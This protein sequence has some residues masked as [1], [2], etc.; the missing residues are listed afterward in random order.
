MVY[1][2][3]TLLHTDSDVSDSLLLGPH[4]GKKLETVLT[5][6]PS[7]PMLKGVALESLS[8]ALCYLA[9]TSQEYTPLISLVQ[10]TCE[11]LTRLRA[12]SPRGWSHTL[13]QWGV[14]NLARLSCL[15]GIESMPKEGVVNFMLSQSC[16]CLCVGGHGHC[17]SFL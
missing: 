4:L 2:L 14:V 17:L 12:H 16:K 9:S 3:Q 5:T 13:F 10:S 11:M 7:V 6:L 8:S 15:Y 1:S